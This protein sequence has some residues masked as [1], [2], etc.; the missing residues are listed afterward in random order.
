MTQKGPVTVVDPSAPTGRGGQSWN[1]DLLLLMS[2]QF[3]TAF[4]DNAIL[5]IA[6]GMVLKTA[7]A[8]WYVPAL[9][10]AFLVAYVLLA[11]WVGPFVDS[12]SKTRVLLGANLLKA[13]GAGLMLA[14][15]DPL[16][17]F[18]VVGAGAATYSPAKYGILPEMV[19]KERLVRINAWIE[20]S[21]IAAILLGGLAGGFLVDQSPQ[22]AVSIVLG[23]YLFTALLAR[24]M[25]PLKAVAAYPKGALMSRFR[26]T[27]GLL[28]RHATARYALVGVSVFWCSAAL[29][30][31]IVVAWAPLVLGLTSTQDIAEL[32][33]WS[34]IGIGIGSALAP[35]LVPLTRLSRTR[36]AAYIMALAILMLALVDQIWLARIA[37]L[38]AGIAGG[39]FVVPVN[40]LLQDVGHH[41][42]GSG[43]V[44]AV[45][46][47][48]ENLAML[49]V[50][51]LYAL[52]AANGLSPV[53]ALLVL[54]A[55]L[56]VMVFWLNRPMVRKTALDKEAEEER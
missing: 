12:R 4:A 24:L 5:F 6:V 38:M 42:V 15:V 31:V 41:S 45:Q 39:V 28:L 27:A 50:T 40:A 35:R 26:N 30:R 37:L 54:S 17:A 11:A 53:P 1:R 34:A 43:G 9:Q 2:A 55:C 25:R 16:L 32:T 56:A 47:F 36:F 48:A 3:L 18:L 7:D 49:S 44:V 10:S 46:R 51:G 20:G 21:T 33:L 22:L 19:P 13:A 29:L 14:G 8:H 23:L 52:A